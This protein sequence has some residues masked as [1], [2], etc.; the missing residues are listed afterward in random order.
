MK[1]KNHVHCEKTEGMTMDQVCFRVRLMRMNTND[2][3]WSLNM[4]NCIKLSPIPRSMMMHTVE[5][6]LTKMFGTASGGRVMDIA[7]V[8]TSALKRVVQFCEFGFELQ[9]KPDRRDS[10]S[11]DAHGVGI[12]EE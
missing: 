11:G 9:L 4:Y 5:K 2:E 12:L 8:L 1:K 7:L 3:K 6:T 10:V